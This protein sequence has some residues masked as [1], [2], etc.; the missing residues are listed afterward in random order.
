M[1]H[2]FT[3]D[4]PPTD[5]GPGV[6]RVHPSLLE[7]SGY[8]SLIDNMIKFTLLNDIID[9]SGKFYT[10]SL[11]LLQH[12]IILQEEV[13]ALKRMEKDKGWQVTSVSLNFQPN[14]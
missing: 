10:N 1:P 9:K 8:K 5:T 11:E 7:N 12:K 14:C 13:E 4:F 2:F 3:I 6:F